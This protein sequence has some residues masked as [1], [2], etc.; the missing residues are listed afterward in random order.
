MKLP[1]QYLAGRIIYEG[2]L[3]WPLVRR[4]LRGESSYNGKEHNG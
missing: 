3:L 1:N 2:V 4:L